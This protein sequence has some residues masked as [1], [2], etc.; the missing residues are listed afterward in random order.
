MIITCPCKKKKF[1]IDEALIPD[2][3]RNLKCGSCDHVWFYNKKD[4]YIENTENENEPQNYETSENFVENEIIDKNNDKIFKEPTKKI[5]KEKR[6]F[7]LVKYRQ[8]SFSFGKL[9]SYLI[10][11]IITFI[12]LLII[13]DTFKLILFDIFPKLEFMITSLFEL[14]KDIKLFIKDLF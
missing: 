12:A 10:V 7:E 14:F 13:V 1:E 9:L 3:G 2:E 4:H 5:K 11:L 8:K 6:D